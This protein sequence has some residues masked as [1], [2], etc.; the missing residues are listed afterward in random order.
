MADAPLRPDIAEAA[1]RM[2]TQMGAK[3]EIRS[4]ETQLWEGEQVQHLA[5]GLYAGGTGLVALTDRRLLFYMDGRMKKASE[6]FPLEK[7]SSVQW[8]SG[9]MLGSLTIFA[10]GNKAE[11][12]NMSKVGGK[13][14]ADIIRN[15]LTLHPPAPA[16]QPPAAPPVPAPVQTLAPAS[17]EG[18]VFEALEK[19]GK[20]RDAGIVTAAEFEAKKAE[21]LARI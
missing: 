15:R 9:M 4:L 12:T 3:R 8:T 2:D 11:I 18:D 7:I 10:S 1:G 5:S 19:L 16:A 13:L 14:I 6:D 20:L 21:L 17:G